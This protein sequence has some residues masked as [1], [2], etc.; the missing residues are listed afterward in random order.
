MAMLREVS[1]PRIFPLTARVT[2]I[3]RLPNC[4]IV[5]KSSK[6]SGRH[7]VIL[8]TRDGYYLEDLESSN[9]T[10]VNGRRIGERIRL[11][12]DDLVEVPGL[13]ATF[14]DQ[15]PPAGVLRG[16]HSPPE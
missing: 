5:L 1:G 15:A 13:A 6:T 4:D 11:R 10:C 14:D 9:G 3:G 12:A 7:A 2:L 16:T 8:H